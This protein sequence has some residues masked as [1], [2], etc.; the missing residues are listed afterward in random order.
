MYSVYGYN[1]GQLR[2]STDPNNQTTTYAYADALARPTSVLYPDTGQTSYAYN[3]TAP[4]PTVTTTKLATPDPTL[5]S[6]STIDGVGH[7]TQTQITSIS[8]AVSTSTSYDGLGHVYTVSNPHFAAS[9]LPPTRTRTYTIDAI[10][11]TT[12]LTEQDGSKS[13]QLAYCGSSTLVTDEAGKWRR[14]VTDGLGRLIEVDEPSSP[15]STA[16]SC[17]ASGANITTYLYTALDD[18]KSVTQIN[19]RPRSFGYDSLSRLT[20]SS[21]PES[22]V[23]SYL[24][25]VDGDIQT[26]TDAR[27]I[28]TTYTYDALNRVTQKVYSD[29]TI[30]ANF[31]YDASSGWGVSLSNGV[32]RL[33]EQ[34]TGTTSNPTATL[35]SYD[36]MGRV[37]LNI[38][39]TPSYCPTA[40]SSRFSS[41]YTYDLA[42]GLTAFSN[43]LGVTFSYSLDGAGR[44]TK[45]TGIN[46]PPQYPATLATI[47]PTV[48][49]WPT[50]TIRKV[51]LG[52]GLTQ[53]SVYSNRSQPCRLNVNSSG[54]ALGTCT[55][56]FPQEMCRI[57]VTHSTTARPIM[58][59]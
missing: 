16:S 30:Q 51:T 15:T 43:G 23:I 27:G 18:L 13:T 26:R 20:S 42:G 19:S 21:N 40:T 35:F 32:G 48:G 14:N 7:F 55:D 33:T 12:V 28:V 58:A 24:Y 44:T 52:N 59:T 6:I 46:N 8:A 50:G 1:D 41:T 31:A 49:F 34:W 10:G 25:D 22:G 36:P 11:R 57:L 47:D 56:G 9:K 53:T 2:G 54:T 37:V 29:G 5:E 17:A 3:D 39:C 45:M 38:W 4:T